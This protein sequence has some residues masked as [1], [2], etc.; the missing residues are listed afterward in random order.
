[1]P[2]TDLELRLWRPVIAFLLRRVAFMVVTVLAI[3]VASFA[4]IQLP[5]GDYLTALQ[6]QLASQG[7]AIGDAQLVALE[8]RYGLNDPIAVQYLKWISGILLHGDFGQSFEWNRPVADL[9]ADRLPLTIGISVLTLLFTWAVAFPIGVYSATKP[10]SVGDYAVT[11]L[12]FLGLAIPNFLLALILMF[13]AFKAFGQDLGGL[14]SPEFANS[15]WNLGKIL[16]LL[17]HL[18]VPVVVLGTA[19]TAGLDPDPAGQSARRAAQALRGG[20]PGPRRPRTAAGDQVSAPGRAQPVHLHR[21]LG[22]AG[23]DLR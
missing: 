10:Y 11:T 12:G 22:A 16:D 20:G 15:D 17:S 8:Q 3:S 4:I 1:M 23:P 21:R 2:A 19:G 14:F 18:W 13:I 6:A 7:D 9:L 5:P